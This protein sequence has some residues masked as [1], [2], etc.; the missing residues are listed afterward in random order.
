MLVYW[1]E[2]AVMA[3]RFVTDGVVA[4]NLAFASSD[5][6]SDRVTLYWQGAG[7]SGVSA[8]VYRR[9]ENEGWLRIGSTGHDGPDRLRYEDAS[10]VAGTRYAYRLGYIEDGSE[11]VT[12]ETWI[13]VPSADVF[14][15]E[16]LRPNPAVGAINV[17]FSLAREGPATMELLDLAGRRVIDREVGQFGRGRHVFRLDLGARMAPGVYWL[18]LRQGVEQALTRAVVMR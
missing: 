6:Q 18:R 4:T 10:V 16:G 17:S 1:Y 8:T 5:I 11:Q 2:R 13:D 14:A 12:V 3:Q 15:L 9:T 7:A